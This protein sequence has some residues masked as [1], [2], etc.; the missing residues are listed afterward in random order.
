MT[1]AERLRAIE[2]C[3]QIQASLAELEAR[4][5]KVK[6]AFDEFERAR[7]ERFPQKVAP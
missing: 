1:E 4:M 2:L 5:T 3:E 7:A 6:V